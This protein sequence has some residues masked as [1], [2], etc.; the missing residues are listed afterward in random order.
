MPGHQIPTVVGYKNVAGLTRRDGPGCIVYLGTTARHTYL[1][2][3]QWSIA[4]IDKWE[5]NP[6]YCIS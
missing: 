1:L 5:Y 4:H 6:S 2:D 3:Y